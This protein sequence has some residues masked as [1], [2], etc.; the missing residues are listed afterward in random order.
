VEILLLDEE[1]REVLPGQPGEIVVRARHLARGYWCQPA[2]TAARFLPDPDD[3]RL[4]RYRTGDLGRLLPNGM[5]SIV[6]RV[7]TQLKVRGFRIEPVEVES[8]L[9]E[10]PGVR[11]TVL[12]GRSDAAGQTRLIAYLVCDAA[13][14]NVSVLAAAVARRL[15]AY[16]I[17]QRFV[18]LDALPVFGNGKVN[19]G[20][21]PEPST[22]R[23]PLET[24]Y[25]APR[26]PIERVVAEVWQE[27]LE[28]DRV[29]IDDAFLDLGG[30]SLHAVRI[31]TRLQSMFPV[32]LPATGLFHHST[33]AA[34]ATHVA[35]VLLG[36][37]DPA[38]AARLL[39]RGS[40]T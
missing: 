36:Q 6:G 29:G 17:P 38:E 12:V 26:T 23:P 31:V 7:D 32:D 30:H 37:L 27:T 14:P 22:A 16:M 35:S 5:L 1:G 4:R 25:V 8:A 20:A 33:V 2:L 24:R 21:L 13:P 15:P 28:I 10:V 34:M 3:S 9:M 11:A 18:F 40:T 39:D 19:Y